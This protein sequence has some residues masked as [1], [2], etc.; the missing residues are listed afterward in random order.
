MFKTEFSVRSGVVVHRVV[1]KHFR[2]VSADKDDVVLP[3]VFVSM[4]VVSVIR[5]FVCIVMFIFILLL[6]VT[7][8]MIRRFLMYIPHTI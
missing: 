4:Q 1:T 2:D 6:I 3:L 5:I 8:C 7:F